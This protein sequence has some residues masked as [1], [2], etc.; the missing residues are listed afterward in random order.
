[1]QPI[2]YFKGKNLSPVLG[3]QNQV[4]LEIANRSTFADKIIFHDSP[5]FKTCAI[6]S[7]QQNY[8]TQLRR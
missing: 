7:V 8:N 6:V 4:N 1:M 5:Y 2:Q 3:R